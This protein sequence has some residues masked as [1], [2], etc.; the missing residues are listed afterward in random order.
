MSPFAEQ[1]IHS[2]FFDFLMNLLRSIAALR[3]PVGNVLMQA[4]TVIGEETV[5]I[6]LGMLLVWC[7]DKK[8][9]YRFL[10][11]FMVGNLFNQILKAIFLIPRPWV[12]DPDFQIVESARA[13]ATGYSFP[14]GHT[15][16]AVLTIGGLAVWFKKRWGYVAAVVIALLVG[17]SRMYLGV[18]TL[19]DVGVSWITGL[20]ILILLNR[21]LDAFGDDP[22]KFAALL[23][24]G[25][26]A[27]IGFLLYQ[28][29][30]P[31]HIYLVK[32]DYKNAHILLGTTVGFIL[33]WVIDTRWVHFDHKAVWWVQ[34]IKIVVGAGLVIGIRSLLKKLF[35][36]DD[37]APFLHG[38][39]YGIMTLIAI[40]FYPMLFKP[41]VRWSERL[42]KKP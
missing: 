5:F 32:E 35:G 11:M 7:L 31:A 37:A 17:F 14:S 20:L 41:L 22:K 36:G 38:I 1:L 10:A 40:G 3:T 6:I 30:A 15:Q 24:I 33:G 27:C 25:L 29:F 28:Y 21:L 8:W 9:G 23:A 26:T 12:I 19:F 13:E 34:L 16:N 2:P 4:V 42:V 18:H 39:R